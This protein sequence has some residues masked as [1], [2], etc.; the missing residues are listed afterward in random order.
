MSYFH[1]LKKYIP[2]SAIFGSFGSSIFNFLRTLHTAL[3]SGC[4]NWHSH[5]QC[6]K[7]PFYSHPCQGCGF[8]HFCSKSRHF[9]RCSIT[10]PCSS[11]PSKHYS[12]HVSAG[13]RHAGT[14]IET[15]IF[16]VLCSCCSACRLVLF[17]MQL[18]RSTSMTVHLNVSVLC[19]G[20]IRAPPAVCHPG[21]VRRSRS[22]FK[23]TASLQVSPGFWFLPDSLLSPTCVC[24]LAVSQRAI[25]SACL[26]FSCFYNLLIK[27]LLALAPP[28]P[29]PSSLPLAGRTLLL[30]LGDTEIP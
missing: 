8:G 9:R 29:K 17:F 18:S 15:S 24:S 5:K 23:G 26:G 13:R 28:T 10:T 4:T 2:K 16:P 11:F 27:F 6:P 30:E 25:I 12:F 22:T 21:C 20:F 14:D 3:Y 7:F 1:F 19:R